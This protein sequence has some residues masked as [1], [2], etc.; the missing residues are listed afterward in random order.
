MRRIRGKRI[1]SVGRLRETQAGT[2]GSGGEQDRASG[3]YAQ[4]L[5]GDCD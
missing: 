4:R 2:P 5:D 1:D 3:Q